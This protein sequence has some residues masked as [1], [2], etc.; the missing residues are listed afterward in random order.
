MAIPLPFVKLLHTPI[1]GYFYDVGKNEIIRVD[2]K[3][4]NY[5]QYLMQGKEPQADYETLSVINLLKEQGYLSEN[6]PSIIEHPYTQYIQLFL[7]RNIEQITLQLTQ[8]CNFRC[9]YC[10]Y[11]EDKNLKQ[12]SHSSKRMTWEL[13]KKAIDF[14]WEH[15]VDSPKVNIGFYGGEPLLE[16]ELLQKVIEYTELRFK[17]KSVTFT[18]T[19]NGSLLNDKIVEYFINHD[20]KTMISLDGPKEI[21][22]M[23]RVFINGSGTYDT[24]M[25]N[26]RSINAKYP[27]YSNKLKIS[28]VIDPINDFD[29]I[30]SVTVD[31]N[32]INFTN[33]NVSTVDSLD[34]PVKYS[35]EYVQKSEYQYFL[36]FLSHFGYLSI[37]KVSPILNKR[38]NAVLSDV[39]RMIKAETIPQSMAPG[40]PCIPGQLRLFINA[41]G[42][43][44]PCERVNESD[45]MKIGTL[46]TGFD[47]KKARALINIGSLTSEEC[48]NCWAIR[49]CI[50]CAKFADDGHKLSP[51]VKSCNCPISQNNVIHKL[52]AMIFLHEIPEYYKEYQ[53]Q[54]I[55]K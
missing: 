55:N 3:V 52:R 41:D 2:D 34:M 5:L 32:E 6:R 28:M 19:I 51:E 36:A 24:V 43:M 4:Y 7:E 35:D 17:G 53:K 54:L 22:D 1:S 20:V 18:T 38:V 40:G 25:S 10:I 37:D 50:I 16:F 33:L 13:A 14:F 12:R 44:F 27:D 45:V 15:S 42:D 21:H 48:R 26:I 23:N 39:K 47:Y 11:S 29:C 9:K 46:D 8:Q 49:H 30:N 31:C